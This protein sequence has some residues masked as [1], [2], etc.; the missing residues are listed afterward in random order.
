M[1]HA[2]SSRS[3]EL[4]TIGAGRYKATNSRGGAT[5]FGRGGEDPDFTP[6]EML[7]AAIAGCSAVDVDLITGKR[8]APESFVVTAS[9]E[10]VRDEGG[11][12]LADLQVTFAVTFPEGEGGDAARAILPRA[13][14][15]SRD[16]L[17]SVSRTVQLGTEMLYDQV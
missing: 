13:I 5:Y 6:V 11:N 3:I 1:T 12:R 7:L 9:A 10:K 15:M 2:D 16:R 14:A 8:S 4:T 17:C